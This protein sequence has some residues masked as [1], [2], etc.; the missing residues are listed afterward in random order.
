MQRLQDIGVGYLIRERA[1][2]PLAQM[3]NPFKFE[4]GGC[5]LTIHF[6]AQSG[7]LLLHTV[8]HELVFVQV[9]HRIE[10]IMGQLGVDLIIGIAFSCAGYGFTAQ[11]TAI[12]GVQGL[13]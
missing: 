11:G 4:Y 12:T 2:D 8:H 1:V 10:Q 7:E 6:F 5:G 3:L 13:R 9:F